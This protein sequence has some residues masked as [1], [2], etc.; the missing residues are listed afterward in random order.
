MVQTT[1]F[2]RSHF[3]FSLSDDIPIL[4]P[5]IFGC[6]YSFKC[7]TLK[8]MVQFSWTALK[9]W[10]SDTVPWSADSPRH[11]NSTHLN[12]E[13]TRWW[14]RGRCRRTSWPW[15]EITDSVGTR[16]PNPQKILSI[17]S[18]WASL[19]TVRFRKQHQIKYSCWYFLKDLLTRAVR[20]LR[21]SSLKSDSIVTVRVKLLRDG[22]TCLKV[23]CWPSTH[24]SPPMA[25]QRNDPYSLEGPD[26]PF[27]MLGRVPSFHIH[28]PCVMEMQ[29]H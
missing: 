29:N 25:T 20:Q 27:V 10:S 16:L 13:P 28:F 1:P 9:T 18:C 26:K 6:I 2:L 12:E 7:V 3:F 24:P 19:G 21:E 11:H 22:F 14:P 5:E 15:E 4:V 8:H 17:P 23:Y